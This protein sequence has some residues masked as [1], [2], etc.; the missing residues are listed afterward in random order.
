MIP[1]YALVRAV[2]AGVRWLFASKAGRLERKYTKAA[3]AAEAVARQLQTRPGTNLVDPYTTAKSHYEFGR[4]VET[5]DRLE[6]KFLAWQARTESVGRAAKKVAA[7]KG[8][9]VPYACGVVDFGLV[10]TALHML[11]LPH[12][13]SLDGMKTWATSFFG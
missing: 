12:G 8:R 10:F 7:W 4:L 5:R 3:L 11:G 13:L 9:A 2:L 6:E 1:L